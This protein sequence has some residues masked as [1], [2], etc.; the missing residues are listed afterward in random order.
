MEDLEEPLVHLVVG[1]DKADVGAPRGAYPR[2]AGL[3]QSQ[4]LGVMDHR[5]PLVSETTYDLGTTASG[6]CVIDDDHFEV[7]ERLTDER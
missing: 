3:H 4:V 2:E 5:D 1:V 7:G 6:R